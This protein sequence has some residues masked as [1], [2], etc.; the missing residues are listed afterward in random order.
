MVANHPDARRSCRTGTAR[1]RVAHADG[2]ASRS[3]VPAT[4]WAPPPDAIGERWRVWLL[5]AIDRAFLPAHGR[6]VDLTAHLVDEPHDQ[7][8]PTSGLGPGEGDG[9]RCAAETALSKTELSAP[10]TPYWAAL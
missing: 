10:A 4:V 6:R 8:L 7:C 2:P 9:D 3:T 1:S 5:S